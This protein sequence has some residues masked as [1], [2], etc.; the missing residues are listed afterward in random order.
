MKLLPLRGRV[1]VEVAGVLFVGGHE[2][3]P[4]G[5]TVLRATRLWQFVATTTAELREKYSK[6]HGQQ[7]KVEFC[8]SRG[9]MY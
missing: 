7:Q 3:A 1:R 9:D 8:Q 6:V 2:V 5:K 4:W